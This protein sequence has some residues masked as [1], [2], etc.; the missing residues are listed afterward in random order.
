M[1]HI[2]ERGTSKCTKW[3]K[4]KL[5]LFDTCKLIE[6]IGMLGHT[7]GKRSPFVDVVDGNLGLWIEVFVAMIGSGAWVEAD[8]LHELPVGRIDDVVVMTKDD[9]GETT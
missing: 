5:G 1:L 8:E 4:F 2:I 6:M 7:V 3:R 9:M